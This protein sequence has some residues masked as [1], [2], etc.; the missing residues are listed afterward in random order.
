MLMTSTWWFFAYHFFQTLK[1]VFWRKFKY[2]LFQICFLNLH[3]FSLQ[4][5]ILRVEQISSIL[6]WPQDMMLMTSICLSFFAI[7]KQF[8]QALKNIFWRKF[9]SLPFQI[10]FLNLHLFSLRSKILRVEQIS[11]I[12]KWPQDVML[13]TSTWWVFAS[14]FAVSSNNRVE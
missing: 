14:S 13:M 3:L 7:T 1:D 10:C 8:F 5:K 9:K 4:S 11:S 6:K 12:L 2:L